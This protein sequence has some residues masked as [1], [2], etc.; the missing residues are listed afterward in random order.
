MPPYDIE[1][2]AVRFGNGLRACWSVSEAPYPLLPAHIQVED[3]ESGHL[4]FHTDTLHSRSIVWMLDPSGSWDDVTEKWRTDWGL[5][6]GAKMLKHPRYDGLVLT[7]SPDN[8]PNWI[9]FSTFRGK[10]KNGTAKKAKAAAGGLVLFPPI[11]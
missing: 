5:D 7:V 6:S 1:S 10:L 9:L 8:K 3:A 4:H 2:K 11:P